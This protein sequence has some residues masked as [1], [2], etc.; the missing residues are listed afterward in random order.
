[1]STAQFTRRQFLGAGAAFGIG[2]LGCAA[3][4]AA[5][6]Q[7]WDEETD[8]VVIGSGFAGLMAAYTAKKAGADVVIIEKMPV[9]GGNSAINGGIMGVPGTEIQKAKGIKDSPELMAEDMLKAGLGMN[10][11]DKVRALC[12][13]AY[14]AYRVLVDELNVKFSDTIL[15]H[16]GGHSVPRSL[17]TANG[18]GSEIVNKELAALEK[19]GVKPR[20]RMLFE[21][22]HLNDKG[23]AVGVTVRSGYRFPKKN[24]GT[25]KTIRARRGVILCYG[26]F[27]ADVAYRSIFDP[28]LGKSFQTTN[29]PGATA[30]AWR[31]AARCGV[32]MIQNDWIQCLPYTSPDEKG[33]GIG[34]AWAGHTQAYGFWLDAATGERFVNELADRKIRCDAILGRNN[35]GHD[36]LSIGDKKVADLFEVI[37][38]GMLARQMK[39]GVVF[40]YRTLEDMAKAHKIPLDALKKTIAAVN[41][42]VTTK[43]DP[44]NRAVNADLKPQTDGPWYVSRLSPKVHHC[45]GGILTTPKAEVISVAGK[46]IPGLYAAGEATGGVHGAVRLGSNATTDCII[47][48]RIA[49]QQA[50]SRK[51]A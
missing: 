24:S 51:S 4:S 21:T 3:V 48:G 50:A 36:C 32:Q 25:P 45:M 15:K 7:K 9:A 40:E 23:E 5:P 10:H 33:F 13:H 19:L 20:T 28:K 41:E 6:V 12:E 8:V 37:R 49:G 22:L 26:G 14:E 16:E 18:S 30:E 43:K 11:P 38:P 47:N 29:Q 34:W 17:F 39:A 35:L 46:V 44:M 2:S 42:S 27:G 1:M 31:E